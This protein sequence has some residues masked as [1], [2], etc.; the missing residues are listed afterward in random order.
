MA[1]LEEALLS[2]RAKLVAYVKRRVSDP[3]LA[4]D[5][6]EDSLL[7]ALQKAAGLKDKD[8]LV[9]WF[10]RILNNAIVDYYR[11]RARETRYTA[12]LESE[13][14]LAVDTEEWKTLCDCFRTLLPTLKPEYSQLI[15]RLDLAGDDPGEVADRLHISRT[16]LKVRRHR[17]RQALR[18]RLQE[19]CRMCATH[20]CLDCTCRQAS[21]AS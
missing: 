12:P 11:R 5:L 1:L 8:R 3:D 16:N 2:Q 20:G 19:S 13:D 10:Y 9:P 18:Q 7:K 14:A 4:E 6:F 17:A 21:A 15:E